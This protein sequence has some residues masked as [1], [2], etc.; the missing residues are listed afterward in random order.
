M[1]LFVQFVLKLLLS[2]L[3]LEKGKM[4]FSV[5]GY[6]CK[7]WLHWHCAGLSTIL[8][9]KL[10]NLKV[11]FCCLHCHL[12]TYECELATLKDSVASLKSKISNL[13]D[14]L[15]VTAVMD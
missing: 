9:N 10:V 5:K 11:L 1:Y 14:Q 3:R 15:K 6:T 7:G 13:E 12:N 4:Q 2:K 8:F